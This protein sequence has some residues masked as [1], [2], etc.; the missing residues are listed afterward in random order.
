MEFVGFAKDPTDALSAVSVCCAPMA[1]AGGVSTK[2]LFYLMSGKRT[3]CTPEAAHG[4]AM[5]P[6]GLWVAERQRFAD[7]VAAGLALPWSLAKAQALREW[8]V[9]HHGFGTLTQGWELALASGE[10][11]LK[12]RSPK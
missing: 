11:R 8:M 5:P 6:D 12:D 2:V 4:I 7:A 9:S 3:V 1:G 10:R